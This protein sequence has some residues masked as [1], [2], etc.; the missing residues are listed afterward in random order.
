MLRPPVWCC[1]PISRAQ[2]LSPAHSPL[3][4]AANFIS[5]TVRAPLRP[6]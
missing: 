6:I 5:R 3:S 4:L 1:G 2:L